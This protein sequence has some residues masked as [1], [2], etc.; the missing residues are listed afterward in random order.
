MPRFRN[1]ATDTAG[2]L[3]NEIVDLDS[4]MPDT[5]A[6]TVDPNALFLM[7]P[8]ASFTNFLSLLSPTSH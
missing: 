8:D 1:T 4:F 7:D 6:T 5:D 2:V 3:L